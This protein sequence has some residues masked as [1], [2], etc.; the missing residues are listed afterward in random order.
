MGY[1]FPSL[2]PISWIP[3]SIWNFVEE[4]EEDAVEPQGVGGAVGEAGHDG[5]AQ[6]QTGGKTVSMALKT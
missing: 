2:I 6:R 5:A 3:L 1:I 4:E